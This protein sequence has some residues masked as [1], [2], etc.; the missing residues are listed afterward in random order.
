MTQ[1]EM[2]DAILEAEAIFAEIMADAEKRYNQVSEGM[3][4][5]MAMAVMPPQIRQM[6]GAADQKSLKEMVAPVVDR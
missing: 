5:R 1:R 3:A 2:D 6:I 4:G